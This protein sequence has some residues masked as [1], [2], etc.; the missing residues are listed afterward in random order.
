MAKAR[1]RGDIRIA[2]VERNKTL[3]SVHMPKEEGGTVK[4]ERMGDHSKIDLKQNSDFITVPKSQTPQQ[5][6]LRQQ[7]LKIRDETTPMPREEGFA[8]GRRKVEELYK[9]IGKECPH[10]ILDEFFSLEERKV[11]LK[12]ELDEVESEIETLQRKTREKI[13]DLAMEEINRDFGL[14]KDGDD[15]KFTKLIL[16]RNDNSSLHRFNEALSQGKVLFISE[17][18]Q[19]Q[20][21][22][23]PN[24]QTFVVGHNWAA[25]LGNSED[26]SGDIVLPYDTCTFEFRF[27]GHVVIVLAYNLS[28]GVKAVAAAEVKDGHWVHLGRVDHGGIGWDQVRAACIMLDAEI[29]THEVTRAPYA[30]NQKRIKNGKP[31]LYDFHVLDLSK[32]L[33]T[34][35]AAAPKTDHEPAYRMRLHFVRGHWRHFE[36]SKTWVKWHM[37]GDPDLGFIEKEYK[38]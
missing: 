1:R 29:A 18:D 35:A 15:S 9:L 34:V 17:E 6:W 26:V 21:R 28:D 31:P 27:S 19:R 20:L 30:L 3:Y 2:S 36:N 37:R 10:D 12:Q 13:E 16:Q 4:F 38:L 24:I 32:R 23:A 25:V 22:I 5:V 33:K 11:E 7:V 14:E 8:Y